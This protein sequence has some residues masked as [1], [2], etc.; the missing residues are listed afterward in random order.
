MTHRH[1]VRAH[2]DRATALER[3]VKG[4]GPALE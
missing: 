4:F 3:R 2:T 1:I